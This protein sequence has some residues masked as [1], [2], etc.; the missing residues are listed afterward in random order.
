MRLRSANYAPKL[1]PKKFN[2]VE[3]INGMNVV[4]KSPEVYSEHWDLFHKQIRHRIFWQKWLNGIFLEIVLITA[5]FIIYWKDTS[6]GGLSHRSEEISVKIFNFVDTISTDIMNGFHYKIM[7]EYPLIGIGLAVGLAIF[8]WFRVSFRKQTNA[9][10]ER[11]RK[12][13]ISVPEG[14]PHSAFIKKDKTSNA[15]SEN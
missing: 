1:L 6:I 8:I 13:Y 12:L 3:M 7:V 14:A 11:L 15:N 4:K 9:W 2:V 10:G 5:F